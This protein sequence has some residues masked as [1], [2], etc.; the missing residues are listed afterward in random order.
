M[1]RDLWEGILAVTCALVLFA[2]WPAEA[3]DPNVFSPTASYSVTTAV[4]ASDPAGQAIAGFVNTVRLV[5]T[6]DCFVSISVT[7]VVAAAT[8]PVFLPANSPEYFR[9]SS[10][11]FIVVG[12][13]ASAGTLY[14]V[15]LSQ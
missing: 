7:P 6:T 9:V 2:A 8:V 14:V 1:T 3:D 15:E 10:G 12:A 11:Q 5:C 13:S 4:G